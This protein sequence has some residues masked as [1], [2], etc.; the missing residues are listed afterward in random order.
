MAAVDPYPEGSAA[1][2]SL[3]RMPYRAATRGW[4]SDVTIAITPAATAVPSESILDEVVAALD[5]EPMVHGAGGLAPT[6]AGFRALRDLRVSERDLRASERGLAT[7]LSELS[8]RHNV[9]ARARD[10]EV[11]DLDARVVV[12]LVGGR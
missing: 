12:R 5:V 7:E 4:W 9:L 10:A 11:A 1:S 6:V 3:V 2:G 8:A